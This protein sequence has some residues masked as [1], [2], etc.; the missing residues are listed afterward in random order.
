MNIR[1]PILLVTG[2]TALS[3][4]VA[5]APGGIPVDGRHCALQAPPPE[6]GGGACSAQ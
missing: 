3:A 4:A 2:L 1:L 5:A 6:A